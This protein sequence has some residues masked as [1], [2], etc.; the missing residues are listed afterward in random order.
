M[1]DL[2]KD[3]FDVLDNGQPVDPVALPERARAVLRVVMLDTSGSMTLT[4][5]LLQDAAEQFVIR[6][7]PDD[8]GMVGA[9]NDKIQFPDR[10]FTIR[11]RRAGRRR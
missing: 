11:S 5:D 1:P 8:K 2:V 9:F 4:I 6:L 10:D 7:L 3:D